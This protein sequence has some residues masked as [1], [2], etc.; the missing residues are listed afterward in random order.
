MYPATFFPTSYLMY[1]FRAF[2]HGIAHIGNLD[3]LTAEILFA[4]SG[5]IFKD[6]FGISIALIRAK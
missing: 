2:V 3:G 1:D 6:A 5:A 4:N